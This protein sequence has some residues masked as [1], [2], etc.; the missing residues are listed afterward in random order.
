M[1]KDQW[2]RLRQ[3]LAA[4]KT[5]LTLA[6]IA[7]ASNIGIWVTKEGKTGYTALDILI[8]VIAAFS[9]DLIIVST[10]FSEK[11]SSLAWTLA[12]A[13]SIIALIF[14]ALIAVYIFNPNPNTISI[15]SGL[16]IS[17][18]VLVFFYSW[19]LSITEHDD[20]EHQMKLLATEQL[21]ER[22]K[23]ERQYE[24][25]PADISAYRSLVIRRLLSRGNNVSTTYD[26]VG[27]NKQKTLESIRTIQDELGIALE[28]NE[29]ESEL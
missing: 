16:H 28:P 22:L 17:F 23:I 6:V 27:G 25:I 3:R 5:P 18:P 13:T 8:A 1:D 14:S 19:F 9:I 4:R 10:A 15:W 29:T 12:L 11:R 24:Q 20:R 26:I 7:Q 2:I 21:E